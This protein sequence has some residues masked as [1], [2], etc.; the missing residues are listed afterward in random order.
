MKIK[1]YLLRFAIG[2]TAFIFGISIFSVGQ[3]FQSVFQTKEQKA[4]SVAPFKVEQVKIEELIYPPRDVEEVKT[5]V[6]E[7][8]AAN[9][10]SE[11]KT[12]YEFDGGGDYYI[13][14]DLPKG[15]KDFDTLS[16][17]T[18][19]YEN[20]SEENNWQGV[21]IPPQGSIFTKTEFKFIR[22]N[23][24]NKQIAFETELKKGVRYQF[25]GNFIAEEEINYQSKYGYEV[26]K[27]AVLN[28]HLI[29]MRGGKKVA[30]SEVKFALGG[31]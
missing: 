28:G 25:V 26:T 3:Y 27:Y 14:G 1:I 29:K 18:K 15:F 30:E 5:P 17:T 10:E 13:I 11:E 12:E 23:I 6:T 20:M 7:Q 2:L 4:E 21:S 19:D 16:I 24:A 9:I 31:C 8:A 22:I